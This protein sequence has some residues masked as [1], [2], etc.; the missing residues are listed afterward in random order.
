MEEPIEGQFYWV[1]CFRDD[2]Y[3]PAKAVDRYNKGVIYFCFTNGSIK[4]AKH[5]FDWD[6][7]PLTYK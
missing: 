2:K 4:E 5:V 1:K 7:T 6:K 3:E